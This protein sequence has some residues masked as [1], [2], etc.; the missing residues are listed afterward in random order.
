L[1]IAYNKDTF[2]PAFVTQNYGALCWFRTDLVGLGPVW[3]LP[4]DVRRG[5]TPPEA[6]LRN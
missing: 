4:P 1:S 2:P 6:G 5:L 3:A